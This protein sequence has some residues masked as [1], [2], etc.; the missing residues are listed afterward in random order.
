M[1][2]NLYRGG[3][4]VVSGPHPETDQLDFPDRDGPPSDP[5]SVEARL[6][7][8]YV[9]HAHSLGLAERERRR[10]RRRRWRGGGGG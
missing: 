6:L 9:R 7:Q 3:G 8:A 10:R 1:C 4:V 5:R 2:S